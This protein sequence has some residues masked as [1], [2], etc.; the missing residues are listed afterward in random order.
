[1]MNRTISDIFQAK[2]TADIMSNVLQVYPSLNEDQ[3]NLILCITCSNGVIPVANLLLQKGCQI[4][5]YNNRVIKHAVISGREDVVKFVLDNGADPVDYALIYACEDNNPGI[6]K[7]L[8][9]YGANV[10]AQDSRCLRIASEEGYVEIVK[11]LIK[12]GTNIGSRNNYAV[13]WA[14]TNNHAEVVKVLVD[15]GADTTNIASAQIM[16]NDLR[17]V[18]KNR[19]SYLT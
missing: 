9:D 13:R 6:V 10:D 3:R 16:M 11:L 14:A 15:A 8:L 17:T 5:Q 19:I 18:V 7:L 1:M 4:N 12:Y 2:S